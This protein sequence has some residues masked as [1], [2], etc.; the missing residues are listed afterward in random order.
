MAP[1][2]KCVLILG[3]S[4]EYCHTKIPKGCVV[5]GGC[6][7]KCA[8]KFLDINFMIA[9]LIPC[10]FLMRVSNLMTFP[11][12]AY[13]INMELFAAWQFEVLGS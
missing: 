6:T 13:G 10:G 2:S 12:K 11:C 3:I 8:K 4:I 5:S 7:F 1:S 9:Y